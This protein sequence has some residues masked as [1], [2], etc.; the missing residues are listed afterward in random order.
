M[1]EAQNRALSH[2]FEAM[3]CLAL[4]KY[5][6]KICAKQGYN[7]VHRYIINK[8]LQIDLKELLR[9]QSHEFYITHIS[10]FCCFYFKKILSYFPKILNFNYYFFFRIK[11]EDYEQDGEKIFSSINSCHTEAILYTKLF[12]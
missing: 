8:I 1:M 2:G 4:S 11:Y 7:V 10:F 12:N 9:S 5:T 3:H 6:Q